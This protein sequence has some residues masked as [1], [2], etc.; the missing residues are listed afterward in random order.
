MLP[1]SSAGALTPIPAPGSRGAPWLFEE[2]P[3]TLAPG[4]PSQVGPCQPCWS[5]DS[6][7]VAV[8]GPCESLE[9]DHGLSSVAPLQWPCGW[10][11]GMAWAG[12]VGSFMQSKP[13]S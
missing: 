13:L 6:P 2:K 11:A 9:C 7:C 4:H 8:Q 3:K 5:L 1:L 10:A 12:C